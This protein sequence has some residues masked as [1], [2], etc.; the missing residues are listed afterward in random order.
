MRRNAVLAVLALG[1]GAAALGRARAPRDA[2][3][4]LVRRA[5][6][7]RATREQ[8]PTREP[9][10]CACGERYLV[11]GR[12]R[13]R[14]YWLEQ[15]PESEPLLSDACPTCDRALPSEHEVASARTD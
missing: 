6:P 9:W 12:D 7:R 1:A 3:S 14:I 2:L 11:A 5:A 15:A 13:H 10:Q 8:Q 4:R